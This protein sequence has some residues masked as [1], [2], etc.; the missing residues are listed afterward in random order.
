[1]TVDLQAFVNRNFQGKNGYLENFVVV[2]N[3][4]CEASGKRHKQMM[5]S[6]VSIISLP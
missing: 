4:G 3:A 2:Q 6:W 5:L 1:M